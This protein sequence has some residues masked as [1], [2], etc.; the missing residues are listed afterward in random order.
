M[1][2]DRRVSITKTD[3]VDDDGA[4]DAGLDKAAER[5]V[6]HDAAADVRA[7]KRLDARPVLGVGHRDVPIP[8]SYL[9]TQSER[10]I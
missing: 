1:S 4:V 5:H 9:T 2:I 8:V 3:L 10:T 7:R 6:F